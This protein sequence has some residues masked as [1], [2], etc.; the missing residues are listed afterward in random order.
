MEAIPL[1]NSSTPLYCDTSTGTQHPLVPLAYQCTVFD[2]LHGL[3][4]PG[5]RSSRSSLR[6]SL[7]GL[8]CSQMFAAG[9]VPVYSA[10]MPRFSDTLLPHHA[11]SIP[12]PN[13]CFDIIYI[14]L[15]GPLPPSRGFTYLLTCV[16]RFTRWPEAIP[17]ICIMAEAV[18]QAFLSGWI[19]CFGV[20]S[21]IVTD[22]G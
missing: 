5:I 17:L 22:R 20:P 21:T 18:A 14:D 12:N 1:A 4:H 6:R 19:S 13:A 15:V 11:F 8:V 9:P 16:V 10:K 7:Y 3:S 2:S